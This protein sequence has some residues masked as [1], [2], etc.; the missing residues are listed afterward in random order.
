[1]KTP[2]IQSVT[3]LLDIK[4]KPSNKNRVFVLYFLLVKNRRK[5]W[6]SFITPKAPST[7]TGLFIS[8]IILSSNAISCPDFSFFAIA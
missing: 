3:K 8:S 5:A 6:S 4:A 7:G 1:M 2:G